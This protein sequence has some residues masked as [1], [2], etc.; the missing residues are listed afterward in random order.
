MTY[1]HMYRVGSGVDAVRTSQALGCRPRSSKRNI[2]EICQETADL[3]RLHF[4]P[5]N[6]FK[7]SKRRFRIPGWSLSNFDITRKCQ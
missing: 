7:S 1:I 6:L 3:T 2:D 5:L 4:V